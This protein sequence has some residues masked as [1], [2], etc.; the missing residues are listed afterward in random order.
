VRAVYTMQSSEQADC[1]AVSRMP[2]AEPAGLS[3]ASRLC[4]T[5]VPT[6][7][8]PKQQHHRG[9]DPSHRSMGVQKALSL[10]CAA[11]NI[12][13]HVQPNASRHT[14]NNAGLGTAAK[15]VHQARAAA[16][17]RMRHVCNE[18]R[19]CQVAET[20]RRST[21]NIAVRSVRAADPAAA[22]QERN[23]AAARMRE[24]Y[25]PMADR[26]T[27]AAA[28]QRAAN[29]ASKCESY[30]PMADRN[31]NAAAAQRAANGA[32]KRESYVPTVDR[33]PD[34]AAAHKPWRSKLL[35]PL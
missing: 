35:I 21:C 31:P 14:V 25:D 29:A 9:T 22:A 5:V 23:E 19:L 2:A 28:A 10:L 1:G 12:S 15:S 27:D 32:S 18:E 33:D 13:C 30:V 6:A 4:A 11:D 7:D 8:T 17:D 20:C 16:A 24:A 34:A 3:R 26:D